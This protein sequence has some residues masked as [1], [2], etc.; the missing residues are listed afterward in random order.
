MD[1]VNADRCPR[2]ALRSCASA[3]TPARCSP[4]RVGED[5]TVVGDTVNVA[6]RLQC[7]A[8][9]GQ[10]DRR[11]AHDAR[12]TRAAIRYEELEPLELKGKS[13]PVPAWEAV[14]RRAP[15]HA[16]GRAASGREAPLVGRD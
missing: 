3:S 4:A 2:G 9:P 7:A 5:Y 1:E 11:R 8:R 15:Q 13:E 10:R 6:A 14:G 12:S 16:V